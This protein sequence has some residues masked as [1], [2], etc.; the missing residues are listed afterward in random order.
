MR[1]NFEPGTYVPGANAVRHEKTGNVLFDTKGVAMWTRA[2]P[3]AI[4]MHFRNAAA[5]TR[6]LAAMVKAGVDPRAIEKAGLDLTSYAKPGDLRKVPVYRGLECRLANK[7][8]A[9]M[10]KNG[11]AVSTQRAAA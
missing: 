1:K 9:M 4:I 10:R 7:I 6:T 3:G 8:R 2:K 11:E 5:K